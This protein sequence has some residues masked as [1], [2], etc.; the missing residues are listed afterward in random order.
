MVMVDFR[1]TNIGHGRDYVDRYWSW[2]TL[3]RGYWSWSTVGRQ[4][5][6]RLI[7]DRLILVMV[8]FG[9]DYNGQVQKIQRCLSML[10]VL[11]NF[12]TLEMSEL[13]TCKNLAS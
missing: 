6:S 1:A 4:Y 5:W 2:S 11:V 10:L 12:A 13:K 8:D 7:L 3:G 9:L